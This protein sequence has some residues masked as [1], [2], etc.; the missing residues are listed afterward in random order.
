VS[1]KR[2][3]SYYEGF[4]RSYRETRTFV[5]LGL[6]GLVVLR[7]IS[8]A[9]EARLD[10]ICRGLSGLVLRTEGSI[11][12]HVIERHVPAQKIRSESPVSVD[13]ADNRAPVEANS[14]GFGGSGSLGRWESANDSLNTPNL[15]LD[16]WTSPNPKRPTQDTTPHLVIHPF[17]LW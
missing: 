10:G 4:S 7:Y 14:E 15:H 8:E 17:S 16:N 13:V 9:H 6:S 1:K 11:E 3:W 5:V 2:L 12:L